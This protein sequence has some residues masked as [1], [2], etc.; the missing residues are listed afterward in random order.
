GNRWYSGANFASH[1][2]LIRNERGAIPASIAREIT[3]KLAAMNSPR[4]TST[5]ERSLTSG[6]RR[7]SSSAGSARS[8]TSVICRS[9]ASLT[10]SAQRERA[11]GEALPALL[12]H[13]REAE[14]AGEVLG[15]ERLRDRTGGDHG[16]LPQQRHVG[17]AGRD[18]LDV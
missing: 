7:E 8:E 10:R 12:D 4:S 9:C 3:S 1:F 14:G 17:V 5:R 2:S 6:M 13:Q 15:G 16:A 18:L 11:G